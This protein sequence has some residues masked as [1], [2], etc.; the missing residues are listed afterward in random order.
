MHQDIEMHLIT[1]GIFITNRV[2][3]LFHICEDRK[4]ERINEPL[5]SSCIYSF[6]IY[7]F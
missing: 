4:T 3:H 2:L 5:E 6:Q 7:H 1:R